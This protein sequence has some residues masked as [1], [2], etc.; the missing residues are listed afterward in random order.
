[1]EPDTG[2]FRTIWSFDGE[3]DM[4][5]QVSGSEIRGQIMVSWPQHR[6]RCPNDWVQRTPFEARI[7]AD[8]NTLAVRYQG[9]G[10]DGETCHIVNLD[11]RPLTYTR[12][13]ADD[14][15]CD[16]PA[17]LADAVARLR[18]LLTTDLARREGLP[19]GI[20]YRR[21]DVAAGAG[22][23]LGRARSIVDRQ[24]A[25]GYA[26]DYLLGLMGSGGWA[27]GYLGE[28][29]PL[30]ADDAPC[31]WLA[32]QDA[33]TRLDAMAA[34]VRRRQAEMDAIAEFAEDQY[35]EN[36]GRFRQTLAN[37]MVDQT[38]LVRMLEGAGLSHLQAN[39][40]STI[41][42]AVWGAAAVSWEISGV[43]T[44]FLATAST[45][46][47]AM[48][49]ATI[50]AGLID[51][52]RLSDA[53]NEYLPA[54]QEYAELHAYLEPLADHYE[55]VTDEIRAINQTVRGHIPSERE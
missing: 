20:L 39:Q 36:L 10:M 47:V 4:H 7:G 54:L 1:H 27:Q 5:G 3:T 23:S 29:E 2:Y 13:V 28:V 43:S 33:F 21:G 52:S 14:G 55:R 12:V 42:R 48:S 44:T 37:T 6:A 34:E 35:L 32:W 22:S 51:M 18:T 40:W 17:G 9:L 16:P 8:G 19:G 24:I 49:Q 53:E 41:P 15:R 30:L 46:S 26:D 38:A 45:A 25:N 50:I 11:W 31:D